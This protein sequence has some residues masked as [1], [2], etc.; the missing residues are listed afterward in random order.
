MKMSAVH[1][2][3][4]REEAAREALPRAERPLRILVVDDHQDSADAVSLLLSMMG[5]QVRTA[6]GPREGIDAFR[7]HRPEVVL[8]DIDMPEMSGL[9][10]AACIRLLP[11]GTATTIVALTA[12]GEDIHRRLS[13][14][15]SMD[16]HLVKPA[17]P[18]SLQEV[19]RRVRAH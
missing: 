15:A 8:M 5:Y 6:Y 13:R 11:S 10:A 9:D 2:E 12:W 17:T 16:Y 18:E 4:A 7:Q 19:L 3:A 1:T 14:A